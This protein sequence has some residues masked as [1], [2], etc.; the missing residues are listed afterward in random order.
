M[1]PSQ[2]ES[3]KA[4]FALV[5]PIADQAGAMFYARLFEIDPSVRP[6][7]KH[8]IAEQSRKLMQMLAVAVNS[9]DNLDAI[10]PAVRALGARHAGY[11][12]RDRDYETV[13]QALLW[14][15]RQGLGE[16]WTDEVE[17]SWTAAYAIL[18]GT[19]KTAARE[20]AAA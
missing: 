14:T 4:S 13:A 6:L 12:V 9:L 15:L 8:D 20:A 18:A 19:M 2:I 7:F 10:V 17:S 16:A 1:T 5:S 11:G 3:V